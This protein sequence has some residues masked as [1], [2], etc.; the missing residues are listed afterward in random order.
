MNDNHILKI[1]EDKLAIVQKHQDFIAALSIPDKLR[2][3]AISD[4]IHDPVVEIDTLIACAMVDKYDCS[5]FKGRLSIIVGHLR[6]E[7]DLR[8]MSIVTIEDRGQTVRFNNVD[9]LSAVLTRNGV[10]NVVTNYCS[11]FPEDGGVD[12]LEYA[13]AKLALMEGYCSNIVEVGKEFIASAELKE[14]EECPA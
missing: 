2:D 9:F 11:V 13:A 6:A 10:A 5:L 12:I 3:M 7:I 14:A 4:I 1:V 8:D